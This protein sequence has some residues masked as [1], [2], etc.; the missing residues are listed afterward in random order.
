MIKKSDIVIF[1]SFVICM[2]S[3]IFFLYAGIIAGCKEGYRSGYE[4]CKNH[5]VNQVIINPRFP[6]KSEKELENERK[7]N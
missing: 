1:I 3:A 4:D 2:I 6:L 5:K 7:K